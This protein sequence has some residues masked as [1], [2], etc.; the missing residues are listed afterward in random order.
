MCR[1]SSSFAFPSPSLPFFRGKHFGGNFSFLCVVQGGSN[2]F[3]KERPSW[4]L[5]GSVPV[6]F[7]ALRDNL[8]ISFF[9]PCNAAFDLRP[10]AKNNHSVTFF[11]QT[12]AGDRAFRLIA[13]R[14][15]GG[16]GVSAR[17]STSRP[18]SPFPRPVI[19]DRGESCSRER[20]S[21]K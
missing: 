8:A 9:G 13:M 12:A 6:V 17:V 15:G 20:G 3:M 4:Y 7:R 19:N 1:T 2:V 5:Q 11:V 10:S 16:G 21:E 18:R 14:S